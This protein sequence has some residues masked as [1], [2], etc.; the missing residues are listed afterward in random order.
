MEGL[1]REGLER[2]MRE[3][4]GFYGLSFSLTKKHCGFTFAL[5]K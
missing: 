4:K 1:E 2:M 5:L 3:R